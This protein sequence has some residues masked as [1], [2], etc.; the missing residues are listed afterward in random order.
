[1]S[2]WRS[3]WWTFKILHTAIN[4]VLS[5][6][7]LYIMYGNASGVSFWKK[8]SKKCRRILKNLF[9]LNSTLSLAGDTSYWGEQS[10]HII[11]FLFLPFFQQSAHVV[12]LSCLLLFYIHVLNLW[13]Y[14]LRESYRWVCVCVWAVGSVRSIFSPSGCSPTSRT[15]WG[16]VTHFTWI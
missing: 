9:R 10:H 15:T 2:P 7:N 6:D 16:A 13:S 11:T 8:V 1:M 5:R 3:I 12:G 4:V 14:F